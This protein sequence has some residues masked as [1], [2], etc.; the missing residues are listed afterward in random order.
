MAFFTPKLTPLRQAICMALFT[1][2]LTPLRQATCMALGQTLLAPLKPLVHLLFPRLH[3]LHPKLFTDSDLMHPLV[4]LFYPP[5]FTLL[6]RLVRSFL[7]IMQKFHQLRAHLIV[8]GSAGVQKNTG[9]SVLQIKAGHFLTLCLK[10]VS[11]FP[12][13][14]QIE[15]R[16]H[17]Q[18]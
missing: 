6:C 9:G 1:P 5:A 4:E 14:P 7:H 12:M 15:R 13:S 2:K 3:I 11:V 10:G 8:V 17:N 18:T 16:D